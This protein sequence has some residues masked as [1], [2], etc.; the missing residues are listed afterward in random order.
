MVKIEQIDKEMINIVNRQLEL[1]TNCSV[2]QIVKTALTN[3][4]NG[5]FTGI[6]RSAQ[7]FFRAIDTKKVLEELMGC[8]FSSALYIYSKRI[9]SFYKSNNLT[10][11]LEKQVGGMNELKQI[12]DSLGTSME[13]TDLANVLKQAYLNN[14]SVSNLIEEGYEFMVREGNTLG[15]D[16]LD[17]KIN[18]FI[19]YIVGNYYTNFVNEQY[20]LGIKETAKNIDNNLSALEILPY[21]KIIL[22][23]DLYCGNYNDNLG[24]LQNNVEKTD[25]IISLLRN[26]VQTSLVSTNVIETSSNERILYENAQDMENTLMPT[27]RIISKLLGQD[28]NSGIITL[29]AEQLSFNLKNL[30]YEDIKFLSWL[31]METRRDEKCIRIV[32]NSYR[33]S[34]T[35]VNLN[36]NQY[37]NDNSLL[38]LIESKEFKEELSKQ[39]HI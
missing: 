29:S 3:M 2:V 10:S 15:Y 16:D 30:S 35:I 37:A 4:S 20:K 34:N 18:V 13:T 8:E 14:D 27:R 25:V 39:Y 1:G 5:N 26:V 7:P 19:S 36:Q 38:K 33:Q 31:Y 24:D 32:E 9:D 11:R 12:I 17:N 6:T 28:I 22:L 23:T 21:D